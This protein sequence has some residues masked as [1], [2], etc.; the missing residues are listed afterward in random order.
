VRGDL[1]APRMPL[2]VGR[3]LDLEDDASIL[4]YPNDRFA[5]SRL[6]RFPAC[7]GKREETRLREKR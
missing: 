2:I 3:C 1:G 6:C 4:V 7:K 5:H